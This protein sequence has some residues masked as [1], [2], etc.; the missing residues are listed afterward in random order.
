MIIFS[1]KKHFKNLYANDTGFFP[2]RGCVDD[3]VNKYSNKS[4]FYFNHGGTFHE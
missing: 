2:S 4:S 1:D 3:V